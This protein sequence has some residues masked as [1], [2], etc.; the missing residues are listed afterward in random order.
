MLKM[1]IEYPRTWVEETDVYG[2]V[3][4][5]CLG[6]GDVHPPPPPP[7][8]R[9]DWRCACAVGCG[10]IC[11]A[12]SDCAWGTE[13]LRATTRGSGSDGQD[14]GDSARSE[15]ATTEACDG[16]NFGPTGVAVGCTFASPPACW[17]VQTYDVSRWYSVDS[18]TG[19]LRYV[20]SILKGTLVNNDIPTVCTVTAQVQQYFNL[21]WA[22]VKNHFLR[23]AYYTSSILNTCKHFR[24]ALFVVRWHAGC[25]RTKF[26]SP[27]VTSRTVLYR[28]A[29][30]ELALTRRRVALATTLRQQ[31]IMIV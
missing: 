24:D 11:E 31:R 23:I 22:L 7:V 16:S 27:S 12:C 19:I 21:Y 1:P 2:I 5:N 4:P 6:W 28:K 3:H 15:D 25:K 14:L 17:K 29:Q 13:E 20:I 26:R 30:E 9:N 18:A 8:N 10:G